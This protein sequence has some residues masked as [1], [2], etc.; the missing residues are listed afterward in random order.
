MSGLHCAVLFGL[1]EFVSSLMEL[2]S[3]DIN[4]QDFYGSTPLVHVVRCGSHSIFTLL[5]RDPHIRA[6]IGDK[7]GITPLFQAAWSGNEMMLERLLTMPT[8]SPGVKDTWGRTP[9]DAAA[10]NGHANIVK[11]LLL[12]GSSK[13]TTRLQGHQSQS[14]KQQRTYASSH[15][16]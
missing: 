10:K 3:T 16:S 2:K 13:V 9:L 7:N 8:V 12:R 1:D 5:L 15:G 6:D 14:S 11:L 4:Q